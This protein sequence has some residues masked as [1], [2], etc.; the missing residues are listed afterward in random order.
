[1]SGR[2]LALVVAVVFVATL[3]LGG[4]PSDADVFESISLLSA[5]PLQQFEYAHDPVISGNGKYVVFDGSIGG[6]TGVWRRENR[7]GGEVEEVAGGD[8][9]LPSVSENGQY[10][11]FTT[12]E[13]DQLASITDDLPDPRHPTGEAP[14]VYVRNMDE[15]PGQEGAFLLASPLQYEYVEGTQF[16]RET[17]GSLAAG[18]TAISASG[19]RVVFVTTTASNLA[20]P[21]TPPLQV[22]VHEFE[23]HNNELVS[24]NGKTELVSV[25]YDPS[26]ASPV[27]DPETGQPEP[28]PVQLEGDTPVGA[29]YSEGGH[30]TFPRTEA[31]KLTPEIGASISADGSTVAWMGED[32]GEQAPTLSQESLSPKYSEPLWRRIAGPTGELSEQER[33]RRVTGGSEP[34][35][36]A[37]VASGEQALA[38]AGS[39]PSSNPCQ[40]PFITTGSIGAWSGGTGE[41]VPRLSENGETVAFLANAP[42]VALGS[43]YGASNEGRNSDAYVV[44][45]REGLTRTQALRPLTELASGEE[46]HIATN[47]PILALAISADGTQVAFTTRRT[48]FPLGSPV[49]VTAPAGQPG[50]SELFEADLSDDTLTRVTRGYDG[51]PSEHPR[52]ANF[53]G[54]EDPYPHQD[55]GALSPSFSSNG[56]LLVFSSTA[57]NLVYGDGNTPPLGHEGLD[58]GS[59]AFVVKRLLF[60]ETPTSQEI[61]TA[62]GLSVTPEWS[63]D[64]TA[65][66]LSNGEVLLYVQT[67][68]TGTLSARAS[69]SLRK[70][71][72]RSPRATR[73]RR[74]VG[75]HGTNGGAHSKSARG[76]RA[77]SRAR[78]A[79]SV[80]TR[81][82]ASAVSRVTAVDGGLTTLLLRL[83]PSDRALADQVGGLSATVTLAFTAPGHTTLHKTLAVSF[84]HASVKKAPSRR[85]REVRASGEDKKTGRAR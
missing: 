75:G 41:T 9:I 77:S 78:S 83:S 72:A 14:N 39:P 12:N 33:T 24:E 54:E 66:S 25:E 48:Q 74:G 38:F 55:D 8:A 4:A 45:M 85:G 40:G 42:L 19:R 53:A 63:L 34:E 80:V 20:G 69:S 30:P 15:E 81:T 43:D 65:V 61:S 79:A 49:Y 67:P 46:T 31:Y 82:V 84:V 52:K 6:V 57:S 64:A 32:V 18:R 36:P 51:G 68:G 7:P 28:V 73:I 58:D 22:A 5:S 3:A 76:S 13:G 44:S 23:V 10:V 70:Q 50:L 59:D 71:S 56:E 26:T 60:S 1:M 16:E 35:N 37:C 29:V 47:A 2:G 17:Y 27:I 21:G 11:S 62:P